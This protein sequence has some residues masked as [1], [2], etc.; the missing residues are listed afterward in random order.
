MVTTLS[1]SCK[2]FLLLTDFDD[3]WCC[4]SCTWQDDLGEAPPDLLGCAGNGEMGEDLVIGAAQC[5]HSS[6]NRQ[7]WVES[8][9]VPRGGGEL[10]MTGASPS[11]IHVMRDQVAIAV[12]IMSYLDRYTDV[13]PDIRGGHRDQ[14]WA[15]KLFRFVHGAR[16]G[17][18]RVEYDYDLHVNFSPYYP[19]TEDVATV[20][21]L[22]SLVALVTGQQPM[23]GVA[24]LGD[25]TMHAV[26]LGSIDD[27]NG[28]K[29]LDWCHGQGIEK[30]VVPKVSGGMG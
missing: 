23:P 15:E 6:T 26:L 24:Y 9:F 20:A 1:L 17:I 22:V 8:A 4:C 14:N 30:L 29:I 27:K 5:L 3:A 28:D 25:C 21:V 18:G 7:F 2:A 16:G 12:S 11:M 13:L 10:R 19:G